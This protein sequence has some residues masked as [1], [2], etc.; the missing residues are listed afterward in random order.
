MFIFD[1]INTCV[2]LLLSA[3]CITIIMDIQYMYDRFVPRGLLRV[4]VRVYYSC[5]CKM[6]IKI[7]I[8]V[9]SS[10]PLIEGRLNINDNRYDRFVPRGLLRVPVRVYYSCICKM[11]IKIIIMVTSSRPLIEGRLNINDNRY[12][13]FVPRGLLR[14][15]MGV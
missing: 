10:R 11:F 7:I 6:F 2:F 3:N 1:Q 5:I 4:P 14:V 15:P 13:R 8:M 9:T 12:D